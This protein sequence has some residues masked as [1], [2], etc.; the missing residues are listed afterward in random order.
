MI[1]TDYLTII[2]ENCAKF[3]GDFRESLMLKPYLVIGG[4]VPAIFRATFLGAYL[5]LS[6]CA[7][8]VNGKYIDIP[9]ETNPGG[10]TVKV[11]GREYISPAIAKVRRRREGADVSVE[12]EGYKAEKIHL[13]SKMSG[14]VMG[15][16]AIFIIGAAF[17]GVDFATGGAYYYEPDIISLQLTPT[18][19]RP[20]P[21]NSLYS[22]K[23]ISLIV[24]TYLTS[25]NW[26]PFS[27]QEML[28]A[29]KDK[30]ISALSQSGFFHFGDGAK[31]EVSDLNKSSGKLRLDLILL[32]KIE[33]AKLKASIELPD[34]TTY[35][36][37]ESETLA[38][39]DYAEIFQT[40]EKLG[41]AAANRLL[42]LFSYK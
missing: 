30:T 2:T 15:N 42:R 31:S 18:N 17:G 7:T 22:S 39:K 6:G 16:M 13:K 10:A 28:S 21:K 24:S 36:I 20:K 12:K 40:L 14:W 37:D 25:N 35:V 26:F 3:A 4:D 29:V 32:E 11:D 33:L 38:G 41:T 19:N 23:P 5:L 27:E 1:A 8:I 34:G 9:V